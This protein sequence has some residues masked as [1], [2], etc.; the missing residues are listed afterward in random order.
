MSD[1]SDLID[2]G[3]TSMLDI[4][5]GDERD[6]VFRGEEIIGDVGILAVNPMFDIGG[7]NQRKSC[8]IVLQRSVAALIADAPRKTERI[9]TYHGTLEIVG[10]QIDPSAYTLTCAEIGGKK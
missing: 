7:E 4:L 1:F 5:D 8:T 9:T 3:L 2:D 6:I 10:I